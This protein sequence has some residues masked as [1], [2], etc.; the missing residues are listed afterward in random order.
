MKVLHVVSLLSPDGAFGGPVRVADNLSGELR[1]RGHEVVLA[2]GQRGYGASPPTELSGTPLRLF[3]VQQVVP[4][5]PHSTGTTSVGLQ[6]WVRATARSFDLVH[7]H[8]ARDLLTLPVAAIARAQ[9][10]PYVVQPHGMVVR[11]RNPL[12]PPLDA[13]LTRR[14][15]RGAGAVLHLTEAERAGLVA[16]AGPDLPLHALGNG[17]PAAPAP[18]PLPQR[19]QVLFL[20]RLQE[21]KRPLMFVETAR[22]LLAEG[23]DVEFVLVG[24]D[25]GEGPAVAAAVAAHGDPARL[26]WEGPLDPSQTLDRLQAASLLVLP[27]VDEPYPMAV[28]EA[29]SV[30][31]PAVVT[32]TCGLAPSLQQHDCGRVVDS[33]QEALVD[34]VRQLLA[35]PGALAALSVRAADTAARHFGMP[36]VVEELEGVYD[37]ARA[38]AGTG[39]R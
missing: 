32:D 13:L 6:R 3:P 23:V 8:L 21:R 37:R 34:A 19:P 28:L 12:A 24:P 17:V 20:A 15:L 7:V 27:S 30:G 2:A 25:A 1:R 39:R 26:R 31:R 29:L 10:L 18:R 5:A 14:V 11:S 16:V 36:V 38:V 9:G 35:D 22:R 33:S 4:R